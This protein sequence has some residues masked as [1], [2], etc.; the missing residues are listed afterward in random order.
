MIAIITA[1]SALVAGIWF[2]T[3]WLWFLVDGASAHR[4][5]RAFT[6]LPC[7]ICSWFRS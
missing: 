6:W 5:W 3:A 4:F 7:T 2:G 1:L